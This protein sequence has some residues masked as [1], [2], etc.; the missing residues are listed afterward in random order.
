M[1]TEI[2]RDFAAKERPIANSVFPVR[3]RG[4]DSHTGTIGGGE[5][6][7]T[8]RSAAK[9]RCLEDE[10]VRVLGGWSGESIG[11]MVEVAEVD[12]RHID[13]YVV[14]PGRHRQVFGVSQSRARDGILI[15]SS[16]M[17]PRLGGKKKVRGINDGEEVVL[18]LAGFISSSRNG[19][20]IITELSRRLNNSVKIL[21]KHELFRV[22]FFLIFHFFRSS[23][24]TGQNRRRHGS[25][26]RQNQAAGMALVVISKTE[27]AAAPAVRVHAADGST[28]SLHE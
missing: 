2:D 17:E 1:A 25:G 27:G 22:F 10:G 9:L 28:G 15:R 18:L 7:N 12:K 20:E 19:D 13:V 16:F 23:H 8:I 6:R 3:I 14:G 11:D 24:S 4:K 5:Q 21:L 26:L